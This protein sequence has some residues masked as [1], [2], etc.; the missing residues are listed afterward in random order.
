VSDTPRV[1]V[2][3]VALALA[4]CDLL[5]TERARFRAVLGLLER[6][7]V[8][9]SRELSETFQSIDSGPPELTAADIETLQKAIRERMRVRLQEMALHL[10]PTGTTQ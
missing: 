1:D 8:V 9:S 2:T 5:V 10:G 7:G 4:V 3:T 6:K